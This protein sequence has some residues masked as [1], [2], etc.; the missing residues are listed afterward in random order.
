MSEKNRRI[1]TRTAMNAIKAR[2]VSWALLNHACA[3]NEVL[4]K[5]LTS[6]SRRSMLVLQRV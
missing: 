3:A 2:L 6:G 5:E 4:V 1:G